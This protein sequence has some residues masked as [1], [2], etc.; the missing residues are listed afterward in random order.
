MARCG[1]LFHLFQ[2]IPN[3]FKKKR[4]L[5]NVLHESAADYQPCQKTPRHKL[6]QSGTKIARVLALISHVMARQPSYSVSSILRDDPDLNDEPPRRV[7]EMIKATTPVLRMTKKGNDLAS[8]S[9][10]NHKLASLTN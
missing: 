8:V 3:A 4:C 1:G 5:D 6:A 10:Q 7:E 2:G 9:A